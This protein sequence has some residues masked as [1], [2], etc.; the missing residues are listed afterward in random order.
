M[1]TGLAGGVTV[2]AV[3]IGT[4][5]ANDPVTIVLSDINGLS[6]YATASFTFAAVAGVQSLQTF[7]TITGPNPI[8]AVTGSDQDSTGPALDGRDFRVSWSGDS[9]PSG[10]TA[11]KVFIVSTATAGS[12]TASNVATNGCSGSPCNPAMMFDD[13]HFEVANLPQFLLND[14]EGVA[15]SAGTT[16]KACV[17][18]DAT[19]D[20][21][22]CSSDFTV[23][24]DS[25]TD[26]NDPII[27]HAPVHAAIES[28]NAIVNAAIFDEQTTHSNFS[29]TGD[30]QQEY[31]KLKYGTDVSASRSTLDGVQVSGS[32]FQFTIPSNAV[33]AAG[34]VIQYYLAAMDRAG[35]EVFICNNAGTVDLESSCQQTPFLINTLA[36]GSRTI[37]GRISS[38]G[39]GVSGAKV[40][41]GGFAGAAVT[42][43]GSG[44]YTFSG[45]PNNNGYEISAF[46]AGFCHNKRFES[47]STANLTGINFSITG[48]E[49]NFS[50]GSNEAPHVIASDPMEGGFN[51]TTASRTLVAF[52]DQTLDVWPFH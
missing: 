44:D 20:T 50:G 51:I 52:F 8:S 7:N 43:D 31:F 3:V 21:L 49:C 35:N 27:E 46:K 13:F 10:Y 42:T 40:I 36:S 23:I 6:N 2:S 33:P 19:S 26:T 32:L 28:T 11:T 38:G 18:I 39:S 25:I 45:L 1:V 4:G 22:T 9:D 16:Y 29:N 34:G 12:L 41:A 5:S 30:A 17:L 14:S 24:S 15:F 48:N 47:V 37:S